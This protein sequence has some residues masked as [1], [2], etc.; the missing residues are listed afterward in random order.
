MQ[1]LRS[2]VPAPLLLTFLLTHAACTE[3]PGV[4]QAAVQSPEANRS[5]DAESP[6]PASGLL[7]TREPAAAPRA[8]Q[9]A[10][11]V[12]VGN[13]YLSTVI[14]G[15][16]GPTPCSGVLL[17]PRLV[18]TAGHC[19]CMPRSSTADEGTDRSVIDQSGCAAAAVVTS[20][21]YSRPG[22]DGLVQYSGS[23]HTGRVRPHP[24][25]KVVLDS[26]GSVI[27]SVA[28]LAV[29]VLD[30][31]FG[32]ASPPVT[33]AETGIAAG[34]PVTLVGHGHTETDTEKRR[35]NKSKVLRALE[36]AGC[37]LSLE[38]SRSPRF[39]DDSGGPCLRE[40]GESQALIGISSRRLGK[41]PTVTSIDCYRTWL[42]DEIQ[43]AAT[44]DR[45]TAPE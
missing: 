39:T 38:Q 41:D 40:S 13:R 32:S 17:S 19:V 24:E 35:F 16:P 42:R 44:P 23:E 21:V 6:S 10:G 28:D 11:E 18:L 7:K 15:T 8:A 9:L 3:E 36:P 27:S 12:D 25:L 14:V 43:R 4:K 34:E 37:R 30:V 31:S 33:L 5:R 2:P 29:V 20:I 1:A 45:A 22:A 26:Q